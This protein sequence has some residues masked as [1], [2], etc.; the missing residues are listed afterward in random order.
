LLAK[1]QTET[2]P[3]LLAAI[4]NFGIFESKKMK[5]ILLRFARTQI[6]SKEGKMANILTNDVQT[7]IRELISMGF[8]SINK[9]EEAHS[10]NRKSIDSDHPKQQK[11]TAVFSQ[12][13][14]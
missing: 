13:I 8:G 11:Q 6:D 14:K 9:E 10:E 5:F 3:I 12:K 2:V 7:Y 1:V 4:K